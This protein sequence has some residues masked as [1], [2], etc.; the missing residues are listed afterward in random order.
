MKY[1]APQNAIGAV[2]PT[3]LAKFLTLNENW[4][5]RVV[6][7]SPEDVGVLDELLARDAKLLAG[8]KYIEPSPALRAYRALS[9][10]LLRFIS[11]ADYK[12]PEY[13]RSRY[14]ETAVA[15]ERGFAAFKRSLMTRHFILGQK[16]LAKSA[17][18]TAKKYYEDIDFDAIFT[19]HGPIMADFAGLGAVKLWPRARW[20][21]DFRDFVFD[22]SVQPLS[23]RKYITRLVAKVV[24]RADSVTCVIG[25]IIETPEFPKSDKYTELPLGFDRGDL[26][27]ILPASMPSD[28]LAIAYTGTF[29]P[30]FFD[31]FFS[32]L[33]ECGK[34][35]DISKNDFAVVYAGRHSQ[36]VR[37]LAETR[38][39]SDILDDRRLVPRRKALSLQMGSDYIMLHPPTQNASGGKGPERMMCARPMLAIVRRSEYGGPLEELARE[40]NMGI[41][42]WLPVSGEADYSA[43]ARALC[44]GVRIKRA[45]G[46]IPYAPDES[47]IEAFS[48][49]NLAKHLSALLSGADGEN[50]SGER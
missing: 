38:G 6:C 3:K 11:P 42:Q 14:A 21:A 25:D 29:Y 44:E 17:V 20:V 32:L 40:H 45:G 22:R 33:D 8:V 50:E 10:A 19:S 26:E 27:D 12:K 28:K 43:A 39:Y 4:D 5:V 13:L 36:Q 49:E 18:A 1:F 46:E 41:Y 16:L 15:D 2:R 9:R 23:Y 24:A 30:A 34:A 7:D 37:A 47:V 48:Y 31:A 35:E